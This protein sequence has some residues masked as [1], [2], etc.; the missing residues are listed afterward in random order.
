MKNITASLD[1]IA[2]ALQHKG[3]TKLAE[4][5]DVVSNSL[6]VIAKEE[7]EAGALN[8]AIGAGI[9]ALSLLTNGKAQDMDKALAM[10]GKMHA[11]EKAKVFNEVKSITPE[12]QKIIN[13]KTKPVMEVVDNLKSLKLEPKG[14]KGPGK[15]DIEDSFTQVEKDRGGDSSI[16]QQKK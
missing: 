1:K 7:A 9:L 14:P 5:L 11:D 12:L 15:N 16:L 6:E 2:E 10:V 3:L 13:E 8:T 4:E